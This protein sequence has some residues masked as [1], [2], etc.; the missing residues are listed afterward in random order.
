MNV[1]EVFAWLQGPSLLNHAWVIELAWHIG[2]SLRD[3]TSERD[4]TC[5]C[6][7]SVR[8]QFV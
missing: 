2:L 6:A 8:V 4:C 5:L 3:L 7:F 1:N